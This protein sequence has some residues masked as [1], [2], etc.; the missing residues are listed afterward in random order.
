MITTGGVGAGAGAAGGGS[1]FGAGV[2]IAGVTGSSRTGGG[3]AQPA[4]VASMRAVTVRLHLNRK[5]NLPPASGS[6]SSARTL[7]DVRPLR[8]VAALAEN[9]RPGPRRRGPV[10]RPARRAQARIRG[11]SRA[12]VQS[13]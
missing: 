8:L 9:E 11:Q 13:L 1:A 4:S 12:R 6:A 5:L 10:P 2:G 3:V 7:R